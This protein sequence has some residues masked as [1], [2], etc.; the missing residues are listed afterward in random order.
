MSHL[1]PEPLYGLMAGFAESE[2]LLEAVRRTR[3]EG[4]RHIDTYTPQPLEEM[5]EVLGLRPT[6]VPL[7]VLLGGIAGAVTGY[8]MQYIGNGWHYPIN[9]GGRPL[10]SVPAFIPITFELGV[11]FASLTALVSMLGAN[12]LPMPYHPV[13]NVPEFARASRDRFF[14]CVEA[15]DPNF[16][17]VR[18]R[19]FL[20]DLNPEGVW[21]VES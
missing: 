7:A 18:T 2:D 16:D 10:A 6:R 12:G 5:P 9:V 19:A 4:Y 13:F 21:E 20:E 17:I 3:A 15:R 8:F 1:V 11:L 14:L